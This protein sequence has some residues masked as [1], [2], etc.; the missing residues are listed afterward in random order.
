MRSGSKLWPVAKEAVA[1]RR[2]S[3]FIEKE[4]LRRRLRERP[5]KAWLKPAS[6]SRPA[7]QTAAVNSDAACCGSSE[8][9][10]GGANDAGGGGQRRQQSAAYLLAAESVNPATGADGGQTSAGG[11]VIAMA[12][13]KNTGSVQQRLIWH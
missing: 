4:N 11:S 2:H 10:G 13:V 7:K 8:T 12:V 6:M 9:V 5:S 1:L 3:S